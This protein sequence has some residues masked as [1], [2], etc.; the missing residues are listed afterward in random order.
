[1]VQWRKGKNEI[2]VDETEERRGNIIWDGGEGGGGGGGVCVLGGG[3]RSIFF[4]SAELLWLENQVQCNI[5]LSSFSERHTKRNFLHHTS[6]N[7]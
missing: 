5:N 4:I 3:V 7:H 1:M 2:T 6:T